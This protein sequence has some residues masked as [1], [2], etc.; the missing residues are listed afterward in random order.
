MDVE[1]TTDVLQLIEMALREDLAGKVD[2]TTWATIPEKVQGTAQF[3]ARQEGVVCGLQICKLVIE[4]FGS[5]LTIEMHVRDGDSISSGQKIATLRGPARQILILER[6]CLNFLGR[7]SGIA[8]LTSE[9]VAKTNGTSAEVFDTR[10]TTP[11]WRRIEKY[12]VACG[13]GQNH[14]LGLF[15]AILIKDNH[16]A[17]CGA[18]ADDKKRSISEILKLANHWIADHN[19]ELPNGDKTIVQLEVDN[20]EQLQEALQ[21]RVDIVLLDNMNCEQLSQAA[22]I[23]NDNSPQVLLEASGGVNLNTIE[24]IAKT[25]VDRISVGAI[26]HSATNFDIGLDWESAAK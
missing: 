18:L 5:G 6:T 1:T 8:T 26:T 13:G 17:M 14:R 10:K 11:G 15:D 25:G 16:I 21:N 4:R 20:L 2:C 7:L 24:A 23:R 9:F 19:T 12:A 3:V 22:K